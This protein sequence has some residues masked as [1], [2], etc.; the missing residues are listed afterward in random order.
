MQ[1]L[2]VVLLQSDAGTVRTLSA[3]L[4][5]YFRSVREARSVAD[6]RASVK[7]RS[8]QVIILDMEVASLPDVERLSHDFPG[9]SIVCNHRLADEK[10]WAATLGAGAVDCCASSDPHSILEAAR[11]SAARAP[12]IAA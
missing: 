1:P 2:N 9:V 6:V 10:M 12:A 5:N 4:S 11:R 8:A 7:K 3:S